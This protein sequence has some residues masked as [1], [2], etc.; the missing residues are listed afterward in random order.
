MQSCGTAPI[1]PDT[2]RALYPPY[3]YPLYDP[4]MSLG[5]GLYPGM[6]SPYYMPGMPPLPPPSWMSSFP[7][8]STLSTLASVGGTHASPTVTSPSATASAGVTRTSGS[9]PAADGAPAPEAASSSDSWEA[10]DAR[11]G[12]AAR[13]ARQAHEAVVAMTSPATDPQ[14]IASMSIQRATWRGR[15]ATMTRSQQREALGTWRTG[16]GGGGATVRRC[17]IA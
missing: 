12:A 17:V 3:Y 8:M 13:A 4:S 15:L 1:R 10:D 6:M 11:W 9:G 16:G 14:S 5:A 2:Y 7:P